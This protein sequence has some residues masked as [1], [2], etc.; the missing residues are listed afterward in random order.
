MPHVLGTL[1]TGTARSS[2]EKKVRGLGRASEPLLPE[3]APQSSAAKMC[4]FTED[5]TAEFKEAFQL[6]D[7]TGNGKILYSQ[8]GDVMWALGQNPTNAEVLKVLGNPKNE[9]ERSLEFCG[10]F[11][12]LLGVE[13]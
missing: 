10:G 3:K 7:R 11:C 6:F 2:L 12:F 4:D 9:G 13:R 8:C 1:L 5:Q